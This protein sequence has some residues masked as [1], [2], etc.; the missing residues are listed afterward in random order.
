MRLVSCWR[1]PKWVASHVTSSWSSMRP[2]VRPAIARSPVAD[3]DAMW[4]SM[5]RARSKQR[6][7]GAAIWQVRMMRGIVEWLAGGSIIARG[8]RWNG[9][10]PAL[11]L[12]AS[13]TD[14]GQAIVG[15]A[16]DSVDQGE[17]DTGDIE[18]H[19][20]VFLTRKRPAWCAGRWMDSDC[21]GG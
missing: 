13:L 12:P 7:I 3:I 4:K 16:G 10:N 19:V 11:E 18:S 17:F 6:S 2:L 1:R 9:G 21:G 20:G 14:D 5:E 15:D 8:G